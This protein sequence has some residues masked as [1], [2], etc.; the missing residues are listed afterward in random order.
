MKK[1]KKYDDYIGELNE[2]KVLIPV[3]SEEEQAEIEELL[4]LMTE[5]DK[6][7]TFMGRFRRQENGKYV[8]IK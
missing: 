2:K 6:K 5:D 7:T 8:R 3:A 4:S 1:L